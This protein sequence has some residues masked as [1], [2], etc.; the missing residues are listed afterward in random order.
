MEQMIQAPKKKY[1]ALIEEVGI[2][3]DEDVMAA[4]KESDQAKKAG[5]K[6]WKLTTQP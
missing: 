6:T 2:N 1:E 4:I 5:V 3:R